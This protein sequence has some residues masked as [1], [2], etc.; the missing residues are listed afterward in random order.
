VFRYKIRHCGVSKWLF[1]IKPHKKWCDFFA[2]L[3]HFE[4]GTLH[5]PALSAKSSPVAP[6]QF[7]PADDGQTV[8]E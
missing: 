8:F 7:V 5:S 3:L 1:G 4:V 2:N 6:A